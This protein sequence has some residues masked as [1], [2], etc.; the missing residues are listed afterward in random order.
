M[1]LIIA[2]KVLLQCL[3]KNL[4]LSRRRMV[5]KLETLGILIRQFLSKAHFIISSVPLLDCPQLGQD[6][7]I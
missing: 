6:S 3:Q 1:V 7:G 2:E 5:L 4:C